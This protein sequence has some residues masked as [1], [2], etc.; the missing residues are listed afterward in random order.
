MK[1]TILI[2]ILAAAC[3]GCRHDTD[4]DCRACRFEAQKQRRIPWVT[5]ILHGQAKL[6]GKAVH[7]ERLP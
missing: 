6:P 1:T 5:V 7:V 3:V 4:C 2:L